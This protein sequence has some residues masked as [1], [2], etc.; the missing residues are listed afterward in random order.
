MILED[1][2]GFLSP[3][4]AVVM[5]RDKLVGHVV[6]LDG[7]FEV[8]RAFIVQNVVF[9]DNVGCTQPVDQCL[10]GPN[11]LSRST[12]LH[13]FRQNDVTVTLDFL[14]AIFWGTGR[15][16]LSRSSLQRRRIGP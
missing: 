10:V 2:Y 7:G 15:F 1:L 14:A 16:D 3:V 4:A 6:T 12:I 13:G 5:R 11:H 9:G 8:L